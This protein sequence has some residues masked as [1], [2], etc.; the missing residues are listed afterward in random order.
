[1]QEKFHLQWKETPGRRSCTTCRGIIPKKTKFLRE[2]VFVLR[3]QDLYQ[4]KVLNYCPECAL[5][6]L[7]ELSSNINEIIDEV[8]NERDNK[9]ADTF[10]KG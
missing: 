8:E 7:L 4:I 1:M 10:R 9:Q 2:E 3:N 6:H 5:K